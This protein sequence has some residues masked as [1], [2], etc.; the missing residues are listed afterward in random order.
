M[1]SLMSPPQTGQLRALLRD[2]L[3]FQFKL[4]VDALRD[5]V[6]SPVAMAAALLDVLLSP[7]QSPR[8]FLATLR[9]GRRTE[10]WI[11]LW[12]SRFERDGPDAQRIDALLQTIEQ[13]VRD[14]HAGARR[15]R[16]LRRW[17]EMT[18]ARKRREAERQLAA[19]MRI[20]PEDTASVTEDRP[21]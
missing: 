13:T 14:P 8:L 6:M 20:G 17:A 1:E 12:S 18:M 19:R 4:M 16:V 5:L 15:A 3:V 10:A 2:V 21:A 11:D 9:F 7:R